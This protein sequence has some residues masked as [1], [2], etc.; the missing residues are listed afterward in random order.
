MK[1]GEMKKSHRFW[2]RLP[3]FPFYGSI[4]LNMTVN[5]YLLKWLF[6][7]RTVDLAKFGTLISD[8]STIKNVKSADAPIHDTFRPKWQPNP[9]TIPGKLYHGFFPSLTTV[10]EPLS[11]NSRA[12]WSLQFDPIVYTSPLFVK[13][14]VWLL[15][16]ATCTAACGNF[17]NFTDVCGTIS[18]QPS[19]PYWFDP[20]VITW[21][22]FNRTTVWCK[23][24]A[25]S[26][27]AE[28]TGSRNRPGLIT[29][30]LTVSFSKSISF[31]STGSNLF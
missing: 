20:N 18:P 17:T 27:T 12:N 31:F 5:V 21:P 10:S 24:H 3:Y 7:L 6:E 4:V 28:S 2:D 14:T 19:W 30:A 26:T 13:I 9:L 16:A 15:P 8:S 25:T 22:F 29:L 1:R 23:P 11:T